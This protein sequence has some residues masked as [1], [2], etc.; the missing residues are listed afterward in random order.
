MHMSLV[1]IEG[2]TINKVGCGDIFGAIF[3]YSFL[4]TKSINTAMELAN[5]VAGLATKTS[6]LKQLLQI[7]SSEKII[8]D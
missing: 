3:F 4:K 6:S 2:D 8:N 7:L 5:T 1:G